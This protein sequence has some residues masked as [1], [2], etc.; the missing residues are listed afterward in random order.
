MAELDSWETPLHGVPSQVYS[1]LERN[2]PSVREKTQTAHI[3]P[4]TERG[5]DDP[6][7]VDIREIMASLT[8][9]RSSSGD[10]VGNDA[11]SIEETGS[12]PDNNCDSVHE[13]GSS[14]IFGLDC[15]PDIADVEKLRYLVD[16]IGGTITGEETCGA[17]WRGSAEVRHGCAAE[18][19]IVVSRSQDFADSF[20]VWFL[21]KVFP[22]L[23]LLG[24]GGPRQAEECVMGAEGEVFCA[25]DGEV[26]AQ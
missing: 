16:S 8:E 14:G 18:P 2:K 9:D 13:I 7:P 25:V 15:R 10:A 19:Y 22:T 24:K 26:A 23:F 20:D 11:A 3:V 12:G 4:P 21:A 5:L 1:R 17:A 6:G